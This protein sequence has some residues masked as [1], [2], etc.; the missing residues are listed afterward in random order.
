[1]NSRRAEAILSLVIG[2]ELVGVEIGVQRG[3]LSEEIAKSPRVKKLYG[4]DP[5]ERQVR[6]SYYRRWTDAQLAGLVKSVQERMRIFGDKWELLKMYSI[7]AAEVLPDSLDFVYLDGDHSYENVK[8]EIVLYERK[9]RK[10]GLLCG[11]D[12]FGKSNEVQLA[13]EDYRNSRDLQIWEEMN[14]WWWIV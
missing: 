6:I 2:N 14:M 7:Q 8:A 12:Y 3:L 13:V 10:G 11:H 1:M 5:W 9:I 4:I